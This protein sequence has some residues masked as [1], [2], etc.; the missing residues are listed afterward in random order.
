M[1]F[2]CWSLKGGSG[3]TVVTVAL[4]SLLA[5]RH[6]GGAVVVDLAGDVPAVLGRDDLGGPGVA[7]WLAAGQAVAPDGWSRLEAPVSDRLAVVP[8]GRGLLVGGERA[9]VLAGVLAAGGR[10]AIVDC[11]VLPPLDTTIDGAGAGHVFAARATHSWLVIRPCYLA[12]RRC[13]ALPLRPSG[14]IV[15]RERAR[16]FGARDIEEAIGA[17][18]IAEVPVDAAV[19]RAVDAG[20]LARSVPRGMARALRMAS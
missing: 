13:V 5:R 16:S 17:P 18:V 19:A 14:V 6:T 3:T 2:S 4:A 7:E 20:L 1:L 15:L 10:P 9:A 12:L 11:G 8:R